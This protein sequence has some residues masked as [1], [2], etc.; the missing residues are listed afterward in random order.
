M[1]LCS[2]SC[3]NSS[4]A[5]VA[6]L[7]GAVYVWDERPAPEPVVLL[8]RDLPRQICPNE[9]PNID[10]WRQPFTRIYVR[11]SEQFTYSGRSAEEQAKATLGKVLCETLTG[12]AAPFACQGAGSE[13]SPILFSPDSN[14]GDFIVPL[15]SHGQCLRLSALP[16]GMHKASMLLERGWDPVV[17]F[18]M[19]LGIALLRHREFFCKSV[20]V[21]FTIGGYFSMSTLMSLAA[22]GTYFLVTGRVLHHWT[23]HDELN[24]I[25]ELGTEALIIFLLCVSCSFLGSLALGFMT[26]WL[27]RPIPLPEG[28]VAFHIGEQGQRIDEVLQGPTIWERTLQQVLGILGNTC[29]FSSHWWVFSAATL[30]TCS[31]LSWRESRAEKRVEA[32]RHPVKD[33]SEVQHFTPLIS[34]HQFE[35][36]RLNWTSSCLAQLCLALQ[37]DPNLLA[38]VHAR[39]PPASQHRVK[40]FVEWGEHVSHSEN[41]SGLVPLPCRDLVFFQDDS[42]LYHV[43]H[44]LLAMMLWQV[45]PWYAQLCIYLMCFQGSYQHYCAA[46]LLLWASGLQSMPP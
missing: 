35:L 43:K 38:D 15:P 11:L 41:H 39:L 24:W 13:N 1:L 6:W 34:A 31:F 30:W 28:D 37:Q 44:T 23:R 32:Q 33:K 10:L 3:Q 5:Y 2:S 26:L 19:L 17:I 25:Q 18:K 45:R 29:V 27:F 12:L 8:R 4:L 7:F 16:K 20:L 14:T 22:H 21:R 9:M 46:L 40:V 36:Q 42:L